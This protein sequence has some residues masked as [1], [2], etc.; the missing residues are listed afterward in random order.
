MQNASPTEVLRAGDRT[1]PAAPAPIA[2]HARPPED[3][4]HAF[5]STVQGLELREAAARLARYGR[6]ALPE[7]AG[8][9][10]LQRLAVQFN[11]LLIYVLLASAVVT[12]F[13]GHAVDTGVILAV[14]IF[15]ALIG[16]VQE[17][18]AEQALD[19]IRDMISPKAS[20][21][22]EGRRVAIDAAELVPGDILL[23]E[24]GDRVT[25]D[26]R[27][28]KARNLRIDEAILTGESMP[29]SKSLAPVPAG[30]ALG[31][32]RSAA[33]SGSLA[34]GVLS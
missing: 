7:V 1:S 34:S 32:R 17:G 9:T 2:W 22:R 15:N 11:N 3:A 25:A 18:K 12:A 26:V 27:L 28:I 29:V 14:V 33:F 8:K 5:K 16:F 30:A 19:A 6:N 4:L 10:L 24:A 23:L 21:L 31:D 20:V 13:L